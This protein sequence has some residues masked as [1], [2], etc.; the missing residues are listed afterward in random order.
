LPR[1]GVCLGASFVANPGTISSRDQ[2][3]EGAT[4]GAKGA[5]SDGMSAD[6]ATNSIKRMSP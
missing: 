5:D 3:N 4:D 1:L 6:R 2:A